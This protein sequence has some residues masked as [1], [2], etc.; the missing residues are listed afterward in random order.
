MCADKWGNRV[1]ILSATHRNRKLEI[2]YSV[3]KHDY[4][5]CALW[6]RNTVYMLCSHKHYKNIVFFIGIDQPIFQSLT[7]VSTNFESFLFFGQR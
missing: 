4:S 6:P 2:D 7:D 5:M 1:H 3:K